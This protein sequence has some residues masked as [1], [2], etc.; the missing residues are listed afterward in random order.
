V[1]RVLAEERHKMAVL[2]T[3]S[4]GS[5]SD[6]AKQGSGFAL[7]ARFVRY[8]GSGAY[9]FCIPFASPTTKPLSEISPLGQP[10]QTVNNIT[11]Q[12]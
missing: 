1:E 8:G 6:K 5:F 12:P 7:F 10:L 3:S 11:T 9:D 4:K 2:G